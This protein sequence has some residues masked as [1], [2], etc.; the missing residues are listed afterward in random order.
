MRKLLTDLRPN[1]FEDLIAVLALYRPGPLDRGMV[2]EF[3][4]RK[5]GKEPIRYLQTSARAD[6]DARPTASSSTKNR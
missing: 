4:K 1:C 3:I 5:H 2:E 6:P